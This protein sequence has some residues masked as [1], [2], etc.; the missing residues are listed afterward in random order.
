VQKFK[1]DGLQI[2]LLVGVREK[3]ILA[4]FQTTKSSI[5]CDI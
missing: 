2:F 4:A 3:E 5:V 1:E